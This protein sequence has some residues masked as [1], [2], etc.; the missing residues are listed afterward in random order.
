[1]IGDLEHVE[2]DDPYYAAVFAAKR[3]GERL[4]DE[5]AHRL[6][7]LRRK[8]KLVALFN[9]WTPPAPAK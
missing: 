1:M 6:L 4:S 8:Q 5:E 2:D 9:G 3:C 7:E